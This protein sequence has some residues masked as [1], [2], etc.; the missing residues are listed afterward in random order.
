MSRRRF[1]ILDYPVGHDQMSTMLCRVVTD[2]YNPDRAFAPDEPLASQ[3]LPDLVT[4]P[5]VT[6]NRSDFF[7]NVRSVG[8]QTK[9]LEIF[10]VSA[11]RSDGNSIGLES[12]LVKRYSLSNPEPKF[13]KLMENPHYAAGVSSL[14]A[15]KRSGKAYLVTG[16][17]TTTNATWSKGTTRDRAVGGGVTLDPG[18]LAGGVP[19]GFGISVDAGRSTSTS[20]QSGWVSPGEEI[21]AVSYANLKLEGGGLLGRGPKK[22]VV[23]DVVF[24]GNGHAALSGETRG[25]GTVADSESDSDS[26]E[27][28]DDEGPLL[29]RV[30][31]STEEEPVVEGLD[32]FVDVP[33]SI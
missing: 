32:N 2:K 9:L 28:E 3:L 12:E 7:D 26:N 21:F 27:D 5:F 29:G 31:V 22:P 33:V 15:R 4:E 24:A 14:L 25:D 13:A 30:V 11:D 10:H 20:K 18:L 1:F 19:S 17:M 8:L 6:T 16:F 23:G